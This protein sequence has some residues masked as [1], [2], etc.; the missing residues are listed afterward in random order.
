MFVNGVVLEEI[1]D[2]PANCMEE[3]DIIWILLE[4]A[5]EQLSGEINNIDDNSESNKLR[6]YLQCCEVVRVAAD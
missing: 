2:E 5:F 3:G 4:W 6:F 1:A